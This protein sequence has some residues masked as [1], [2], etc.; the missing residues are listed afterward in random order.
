MKAVRNDIAL[1]ERDLKARI[2]IC[3][4][5]AP[6]AVEA[7]DDFERALGFLRALGVKA[8]YP[9]LPYADISVWAY[10]R[11][12]RENGGGSVLTSFCARM[13]NFFADGELPRAQA[14]CT[15]APLDSP[16]VC[17]AKYLRTYRGVTER[18]AF[19]SPCAFKWREFTDDKGSQ[20][21]HYHLPI[22][23]FIKWLEAQNANL[24]DYAPCPLEHDGAVTG[25]T[26]GALGSFSKALALLFDSLSYALVDGADAVASYVLNNSPLPRVV[27]AYA[28][29]GGCS[30]GGAMG[31]CATKR[32]ASSQTK[33]KS[34]PCER[35]QREAIMRRFAYYDEHL[36]V[37]HFYAKKTLN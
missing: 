1:F 36:D 9:V 26:V 22:A 32:F 16:L 15:S 11:F 35:A 12:L 23:Q 34:Q 13:R 6:V 31:Q 14:D 10:Y 20:L 4:L 27:E 17:A 29:K 5:A 24:R 19:L 3:V 28:C 30:N 18:L 33:S 21:L 25:V 7:I 2:P 8:C 37:E